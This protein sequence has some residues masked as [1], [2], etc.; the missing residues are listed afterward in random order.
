MV[1]VGQTAVAT[2]RFFGDGWG[3]YDSLRWDLYFQGALVASGPVPPPAPAGAGRSTVA[4]MSLAYQ[5][6]LRS[7]WESSSKRGLAQD[8]PMAMTVYV[9]RAADQRVVQKA[10]AQFSAECGR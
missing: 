1:A 2:I 5:D 6:C 10:S 9:R 8:S 4:P 7:A 3:D